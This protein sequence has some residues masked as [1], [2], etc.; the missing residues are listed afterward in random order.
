MKVW[1]AQSSSNLWL[2]RA[3]TQE[4]PYINA[5]AHEH[6]TRTDLETTADQWLK[7]NPAGNVRVFELVQKRSCTA[8]PIKV[9]TF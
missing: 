9:E 7:A 6:K 2:Q 8:P 1:I 5:P 3:A 4:A